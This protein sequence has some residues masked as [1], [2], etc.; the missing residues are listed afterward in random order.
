MQENAV[1]EDVPWE[2]YGCRARTL[3]KPVSPGP[4]KE[5]QGSGGTNLRQFVGPAAFWCCGKFNLNYQL[6]DCFHVSEDTSL[7]VHSVR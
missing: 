2:C 3:F 5:W 6:R 4:L 7:H 1:Q